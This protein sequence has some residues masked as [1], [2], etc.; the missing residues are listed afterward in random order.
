MNLKQILTYSPLIGAFLIFLGALKLDLIYSHFDINIFNFL[1]FSEILTL[2]LKDI[3]IILF[4][5]LL[6]TFHSVLGTEVFIN[7]IKITINKNRHQPVNGEVIRRIL[8]TKTN[9]T[10]LVILSLIFSAVGYFCLFHFKKTW[11]LYL[12]VL[13][14]IQIFLVFL[15]FIQ[16]RL[17]KFSDKTYL[18]IITLVAFFISHLVSQALRFRKLIAINT[19]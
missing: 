19:E 9:N 14:T 6:M 10:H 2:F 15:E 18:F 4:S 16:T 1:D 12:T 8:N 11:I 17:I 13:F 7:L 5:V 3:N